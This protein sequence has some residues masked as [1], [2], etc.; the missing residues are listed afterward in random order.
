MQLYFIKYISFVN[1][2]FK[3]IFRR[4]KNLRNYMQKQLVLFNVPLNALLFY[5]ASMQG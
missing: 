5:D 2:L 4:F 1:T 3:K